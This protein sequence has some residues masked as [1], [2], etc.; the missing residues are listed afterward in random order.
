MTTDSPLRTRLR[1]ALLEARKARDAETVST[2]RTAL[3]ALENAEAVPTDA[4]AGALED[5][6]VGVGV[7]EAARRVLSDAEELAV[8]EAEIAS[9]QEAGR[10]YA[11]S[12]PERAVAARRAAERLS[13][14]R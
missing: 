9:L 8:L 1:T 10:S 7:T 6:P 5:A 11:C 2:L 4:T 12:V 3:A 14:L 13:A